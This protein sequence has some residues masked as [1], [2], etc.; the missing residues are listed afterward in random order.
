MVYAA[1]WAVAAVCVV[2]AAGVAGAAVCVATAA[3]LT[4]G[5]RRP[6]PWLL[7]VPAALAAATVAVPTS[8]TW[9]RAGPVWLDAVVMAPVGADP[10]AGETWLRLAP[11]GRRTPWLRCVVRG[12]LEVLPGDVVRGP[13][14]L[15][16][17]A[18]RQRAGRPPVVTAQSSGLEVQPGGP[19]FRR[20][21][22][23][24]R[25]RMQAALLDAVP[26]DEGVLLCHLVLG[27][28]PRLPERLTSAHRATGL[29]HLLAVS[30]AHASMLA[31][32]TGM[33]F[34][35]WTRRSPLASP[36]YRWFCGGFLLT[37]GAV[38]GME[39]PVLRAVLAFCL[40]LGAK[41]GGRQI[42]VTAA[43]AFPAL[44]TAVVAPDDVLGASFCLSYAAV[45]GLAMAGV[46]R[47]ESW[48]GRWVHTPLVASCWATLATAPL[49]LQFFGQIA[50][51]SILATPLLAPLVGLMLA[52]GLVVAA[53]G[54]C[55]A[56]LAEVLALPLRGISTAYCAAVEGTAMLPLTPVF[57]VSQPPLGVQL[58]CGLL[59]TALLVRR[60][61]RSSVAA[62]CALLS[63]L[64]FL[65][66]QPLPPGLTLRA[67][68]HGQVCVAQLSSGCNVLVDCGSLGDP[69]GPAR[70]AAQALL[71]RRR[72]DL[73]VLTHGDFDHVGAVPMLLELL[74]VARAVLP[75]ELGTGPVGRA[76]RAKSVA[77]VLIRRGETTVVTSG[78][79][80]TR[81]VVGD[82]S[83]N[84]T[85]LW[86]HVTPGACSVLL[87]GDAEEAGVRCWLAASA[88][89]PGTGLDQRGADVLVLPHHGRP[90][91]LAADLLAAVRPRLAL[92]SNREADGLSAQGEL[93][94]A[95]G[96]TV[97]ETG[98]S[99]DIRIDAGGPIQVWTAVPTQ[100]R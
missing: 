73:L 33:V 96:V 1:L 53:A 4:V 68:G 2:R 55:S 67:V 36:R 35:W 40:V 25:L 50:P 29:T 81:P 43:L 23:W 21:T 69:T 28:G 5:T 89:G 31:L 6:G 82:G 71:P 49:T 26:G 38:T 54:G 92:V 19:S 52:G 20:L 93:A 42:T 83:R 44:A 18:R 61:R 66:A 90:H 48:T 12:N 70:A 88:G 47:A 17:Q 85:G 34:G 79:W 77:L 37:Y 16:P 74:P 39:P 100:L 58:G 60:P 45:I 8:W 80:V 7:A 63:L 9:P 65:P 51:W 22:E 95:R 10:R 97:L 98:S 62:L 14:R 84:D 86:V 99:G 75:A 3:V 13:A 27:R 46:F 41:A 72:L 32:L 57:A 87:A 76:L 30:G 24:L 94:R 59:G 56:L 15:A 78:L 91:D 64:H 11:G